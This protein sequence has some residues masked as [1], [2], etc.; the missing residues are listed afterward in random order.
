MTLP[1]ALDRVGSPF[2][3]SGVGSTQASVTCR[4][5]TCSYGGYKLK[6]SMMAL[7]SIENVD[8]LACGMV[9]KNSFLSSFA[10]L[11]I[12][13]RRVD[14]DSVNSSCKVSHGDPHW[15]SQDQWQSLNKSVDGRLLTGI[16]P[17]AVCDSSLP[18]Y[19]AASCRNVDSFYTSTAFHVQ[20]PVS[21]AAANWE[22]DACLP[23]QNAS[24]RIDQFPR[25]VINASQAS[26]VQAGVS[27]ASKYHIR[28]IV[29]GTGHDYLGR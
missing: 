19:N 7:I 14:S 28:L 4:S 2:N 3:S 16:P 5:K 25:Y 8:W 27:F 1:F 18:E 15:P 23:I 9:I 29:K 20:D 24:C 13:T 11:H 21:L 10:L 17:A 6:L 12:W 22:D 26:H